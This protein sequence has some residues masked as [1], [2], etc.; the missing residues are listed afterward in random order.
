MNKLLLNTKQAAETVGLSEWTI[1][2]YIRQGRIPC[3]KI[4]RRVLVEPAELQRLV[5]RGRAGGQ[6]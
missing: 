2:A 4:G 3:V 1:R 5:D 6:Q